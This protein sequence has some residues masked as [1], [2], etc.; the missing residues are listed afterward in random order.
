MLILTYSF[1]RRNGIPIL[2]HSCPHNRVRM[3]HITSTLLR[4]VFVV[5]RPGLLYI[6]GDCERDV[7][8]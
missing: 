4:K 6:V 3:Y 2:R 8:W 1:H 7:L 5:I